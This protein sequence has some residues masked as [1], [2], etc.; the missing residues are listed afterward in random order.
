MA[1]VAE[2]RADVAARER[3]FHDALAAPLSALQLPPREPDYLD[4]ALLRRVGALEGCS[5]LELGC[6]VGDL[7]LILVRYDISLTAVDLSAGMIDIARARAERFVPNARTRFLAVP[8]EDTGLPEA[9]FDVIVGKWILHHADIAGAAEEIHRL[10]RPGGRAVF[11]ENWGRN[12]LLMFGR[13]HLAGRFGI[14]K[15]GTEDE[16]PLTTDDYRRFRERF[17]ITEAEF[18]DFFFWQL[19][20]RQLLGYRFPFLSATARWAD[21]ETWRWIPALRRYSYHIILELRKARE[22]D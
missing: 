16:H 3:E 18:P 20:D 11:I 1:L 17:Q 14:P 5:L 2:S 19:V 21:R 7:S 9:S 10:L 15:Y 6:G 22:S 8:I 13:N 12:R 4:K